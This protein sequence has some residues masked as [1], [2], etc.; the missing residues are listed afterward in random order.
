MEILF[1]ALDFRFRV[2]IYYLWKFHESFNETSEATKRFVDLV[3]SFFPYSFLSLSL[4]TQRYTI[5]YQV[6]HL[7]EGRCVCGNAAQVFFYYPDRKRGPRRARQK[8]PRGS[9]R[10]FFSRWKRADDSRDRDRGA[11]RS[12]FLELASKGNDKYFGQLFIY[13]KFD[14]LRNLFVLDFFILSSL[15]FRLFSE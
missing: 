2:S 9:N 7:G 1:S 10:G 3:S 8:I 14:E 6:S 12:L 4:F 13:Q 5:V 15:S 11:S